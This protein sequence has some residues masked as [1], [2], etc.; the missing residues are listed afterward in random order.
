VRNYSSW[1]E[2]YKDI[3]HPW[4]KT[5][6]WSAED[7]LV[8]SSMPFG[9]SEEAVGSKLEKEKGS[10]KDLPREVPRRLL[11]S[12]SQPGVTFG[13]TAISVPLSVSLSCAG[14]DSESK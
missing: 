12:L 7:G 11:S 2:K 1:L 13:S 9:R 8:L 3:T 14:A 10:I 5:H 4:T 6:R